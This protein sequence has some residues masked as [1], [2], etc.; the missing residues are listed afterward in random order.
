MSNHLRVQCPGCEHIFVPEFNASIQEMDE[1]RPNDRSSV[2]AWY[3]LAPK[4]RIVL[5]LMAE[6][7]TNE[8]IANIVGW[9]G[10][11]PNT[12]ARNYVAKIFNKL[13]CNRRAEA[14]LYVADHPVLRKMLADELRE[15]R[16]THTATEV[17]SE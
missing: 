9:R 13:G 8:E 6:A 7:H 12:V 17:S 10:V 1:C 5:A 16:T 15:F 2:R 3:Q 11:S 4:E 14:I